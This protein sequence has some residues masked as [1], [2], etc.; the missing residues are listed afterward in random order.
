MTIYV[1]PS[2]SRSVIT[3]FVWALRR[4]A[5][6]R[7]RLVGDWDPSVEDPLEVV[8]GILEE[9]YRRLQVLDAVE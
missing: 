5:S 4:S 7:D 9:V 6:R 2:F 1:V 8:A 3:C